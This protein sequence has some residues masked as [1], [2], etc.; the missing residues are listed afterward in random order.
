MKRKKYR[1]DNEDEDTECS[2]EEKGKQRVSPDIVSSEEEDHDS[3][4]N[5]TTESDS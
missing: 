2:V 1:S 4:W 3:Y 5:S